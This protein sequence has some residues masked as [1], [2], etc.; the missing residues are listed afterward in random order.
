MA[1]VNL[2]SVAVIGLA[3][4]AYGDIWRGAGSG[5]G[6]AAVQEIREVRPTAAE[7]R[8]IAKLLRPNPPW[9]CKEMD[10]HQDWLNNLQYRS[11]P[12]SKGARVFLVE[13]GAGCARGAGANGAMWLVRLW[14]QAR[15]IAGPRQ[16]FDG[17]V[18]SV[19]LSASKGYRDVI[20]GWHMSAAESGL[21]YFRFDGARYRRIGLATAVYG[22]KGLRIIPE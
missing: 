4:A 19:P 14:P 20:L 2:L 16:E 22:E 6:R 10:P 13:A 12:V 8:V 3:T 9:S 5:K 1:R 15:V 21:A 18:W 7:R 17:Y 11:I